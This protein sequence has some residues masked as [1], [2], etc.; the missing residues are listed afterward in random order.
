[1]ELYIIWPPSIMI[2]NDRVKSTIRYAGVDML[3]RTR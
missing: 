1:M 3:E 2:T